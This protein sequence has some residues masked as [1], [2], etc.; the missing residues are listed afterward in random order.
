[1]IVFTGRLA[2]SVGDVLGIEAGVRLYSFLKWPAL[3]V[4]LT[5]LIG[6]C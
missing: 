2:G 4:V 6:R 5:L 1:L 3:L